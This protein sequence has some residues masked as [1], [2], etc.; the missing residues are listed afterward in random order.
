MDYL[1]KQKNLDYDPF[2][3]QTREINSRLLA[4]PE[5]IKRARAL[6]EE[7]IKTLKSP[8]VIPVKSFLKISEALEIY[9]ESKIFA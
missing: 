2:S 5:N 3:Q 1:K 7:I 8:N 9:L 4:S 6:R